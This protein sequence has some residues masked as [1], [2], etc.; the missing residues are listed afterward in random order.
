MKKLLSK[1]KET[2]K[3]SELIKDLQRIHESHGEIEVQL[4]G[5]PDDESLIDREDDETCN[6]ITS[7]NFFIAEENYDNEWRISLRTWPY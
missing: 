5:N 3:I 1:R 6:F 2:V 7:E 4:Q